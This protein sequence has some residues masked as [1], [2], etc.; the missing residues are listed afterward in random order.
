MCADQ[1][2]DRPGKE[3]IAPLKAGMSCD[4]V[5]ECSQLRVR[6]ISLL[7]GASRCAANR[8]ETLPDSESSPSSREQTAL[9][10]KIQSSNGWPKRAAQPEKPV[11]V[12]QPPVSMMEMETSLYHG[13]TWKASPDGHNSCSAYQLPSTRALTAPTSRK[14]VSSTKQRCPILHEDLRRPRMFEDAWLDDQEA[15]IPQCVNSLFESM[16]NGRY[17]RILCYGGLRRSLLTLYRG[18]ECSLL[19]NQLEASISYGCLSRP[20]HSSND[21]SFL[22]SDVRICQNFISL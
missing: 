17:G 12:R 21:G 1:I 7:E 15:R 10:D 2:G 13:S 16:K 11:V 9:Y 8:L 4:K 20:K 22:K 19:H 18:A 14:V 5:R 6:G 3:I